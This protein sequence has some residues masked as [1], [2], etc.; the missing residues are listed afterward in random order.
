[1]LGI[2]LAGSQF[3][4]LPATAKPQQDPQPNV[5]NLDNPQWYYDNGNLIAIC[6]QHN[7]I[8][9][10]HDQDFLAPYITNY[11]AIIVVKIH[12]AID[13]ISGAILENFL[14]STDE[15]AIIGRIIILEKSSWRYKT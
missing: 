3:I 6:N 1:M 15:S 4:T 11:Y 7:W 12:P 5:A 9:I 10:T 13:A 8:L 14:Q 2:G